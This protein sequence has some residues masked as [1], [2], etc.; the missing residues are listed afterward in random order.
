[1]SIQEFSE[2]YKNVLINISL[3]SKIT[4]FLIAIRLLIDIFHNAYL[5]LFY[6]EGALL[7]ESLDLLLISNGFQILICLAFITRFIF[8]WSKESRFVWVSQITWLSGWLTIFAYGAVTNI[9]Y[10]RNFFF[11]GYSHY[12]LWSSEGLAVLLLIYLFLSPIKQIFILLF[13]LLTK[14]R[15]YD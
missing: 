11:S 9:Y 12:F 8:L 15:N 4:T 6:A 1:M 2:N 5:Y 7:K 3:L 13:S 14:V 10:P